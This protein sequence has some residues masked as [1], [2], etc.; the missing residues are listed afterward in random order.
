MASQLK[1]GLCCV[2]HCWGVHEKN[3]TVN[4]AVVSVK[5]I[6]QPKEWPLVELQQSWI[7]KNG[8]SSHK[9]TKIHTFSILLPLTIPIY[10]IT[11][12]LK[13]LRTQQQMKILFFLLPYL[14]LHH[15]FIDQKLVISN[16]RF[17]DSMVLL[18]RGARLGGKKILLYPVGDPGFS[19]GGGTNPPNFFP[20]FSPKLHEIE[21]FWTLGVRVQ[22]CT[23]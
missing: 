3:S 12:H 19:R 14:F 16:Q 18:V 9:S 21:R 11:I 2:Q 13:W 7:Q 10:L 4:T 5:M 15:V 8:N 17:R 6:R 23:M 22:N 1:N 20:K